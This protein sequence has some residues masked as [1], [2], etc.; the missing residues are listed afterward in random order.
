MKSFFYVES[1][2]R[3]KIIDCMWNIQRMSFYVENLHLYNNFFV[4]V[5]CV[6]HATFWYSLK[7]VL[8]KDLGKTQDTLSIAP[9][10]EILILWN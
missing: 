2:P 4:R 10:L 7:I 8:Q 9:L 1:T 5:Y 3:K 6:K